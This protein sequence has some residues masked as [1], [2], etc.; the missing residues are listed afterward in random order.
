MAVAR[1]LLFWSSSLGRISL[2]GMFY[3]LT[4]LRQTKTPYPSRTSLKSL[5]IPQDSLMISLK[6]LACSNM[7][8]RS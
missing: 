2:L 8:S 6:V 5:P 1:P 7:L 3:G 4:R